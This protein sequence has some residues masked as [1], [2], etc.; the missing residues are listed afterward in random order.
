MPVKQANFYFDLMKSFRRCVDQQS[1]FLPI[2]PKPK[3][4][5]INSDSHSHRTT[6]NNK[7]KTSILITIYNIKQPYL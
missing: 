4:L 7:D 1:E 5:I 2:L 6:Y 3:V